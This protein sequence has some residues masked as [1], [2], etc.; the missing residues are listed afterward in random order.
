VIKT[1]KL[2]YDR[3][4]GHICVNVSI[5][6]VENKLGWNKKTYI[7]HELHKVTNSIIIQKTGKNGREPRRIVKTSGKYMIPILPKLARI[8][9]WRD[10]EE[11]NI[12]ISN[13]IM[14]VQ[15][16]NGYVQP[17]DLITRIDAERHINMNKKQKD[18]FKSSAIPNK[19]NF[20]EH[21]CNKDFVEKKTN[22]FKSM[23]KEKLKEKKTSIINKEDR[24]I[25][26][27]IETSISAWRSS[28]RS[29]N[30]WLKIL[31]V[32]YKKTLLNE[33]RKIL[34]NMYGVPTYYVNDGKKRVKRDCK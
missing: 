19:K 30:W 20:K 6:D 4:N 15:S 9:N 8:L 31:C 27:N 24:F 3:K 14:T 13:G 16:K 25:I 17:L 34:N 22:Y 29:W 10:K 28:Y 33:K 11:M 21:M 26:E 32:M 18:F 7:N 2:R 12:I 1:V 5:P 23:Y